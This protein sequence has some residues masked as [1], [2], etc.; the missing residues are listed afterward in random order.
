MHERDGNRRRIRTANS[1]N[2][3]IG[4]RPVTLPALTAKPCPPRMNTVGERLCF[5]FP[6]R[7]REPWFFFLAIRFKDGCKNYYSPNKALAEYIAF[8]GTVR[9]ASLASCAEGHSD[10]GNYLKPTDNSLYRCVMASG[11]SLDDRWPVPAEVAFESIHMTCRGRGRSSAV[12]GNPRGPPG[13]CLR[14]TSA[15]KVAGSFLFLPRRISSNSS[16]CDLLDTGPSGPI[17]LDRNSLPGSAVRDGPNQTTKV[18]QMRVAK[19]IAPFLMIALVVWF[20]IRRS[21]EQSRSVNKSSAINS[22]LIEQ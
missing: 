1:S 3:G 4:R 7:V 17:Q 2:A 6:D 16:T 21:M 18:G 9:N 22:I 12:L 13:A 15:A 19:S 8:A 10:G 5:D 14:T 20:G 11:R